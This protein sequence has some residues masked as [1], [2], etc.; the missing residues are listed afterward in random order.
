MACPRCKTGKMHIIMMFG[1]RG[2]PP[3]F[4]KAGDNNKHG[5]SA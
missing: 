1:I 2:P 3:I 5:A 4:E